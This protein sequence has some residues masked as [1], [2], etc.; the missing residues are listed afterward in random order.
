MVKHSKKDK[1]IQKLEKQ[2]KKLTKLVKTLQAFNE[3][4]ADDAYQNFISLDDKLDKLDEINKKVVKMEEKYLSSICWYQTVLDRQ[5]R[6][7]CVK[8]LDEEGLA[9]FNFFHDSKRARAYQDKLDKEKK[10]ETISG[11]PEAQENLKL[12]Y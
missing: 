2:V 3:A 7:L 1:K 8:L 12:P 4:N 10:E 11:S 5:V 9:K 6:E